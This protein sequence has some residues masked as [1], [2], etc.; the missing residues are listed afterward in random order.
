LFPIHRIAILI[1]HDKAIGVTIV[2]DASVGPVVLHRLAQR[3]DV[4]T[5]AASIYVS[6][7]GLIANDHKIPANLSQNHRTRNHPSTIRNI[8]NNAPAKIEPNVAK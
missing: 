4:F 2:G 5:A 8:Q 7:V 1:D 3:R 6:P